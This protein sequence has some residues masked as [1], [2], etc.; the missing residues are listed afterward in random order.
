MQ[1]REKVALDQTNQPQFSGFN[2]D[3]HTTQSLTSWT[4]K[5]HSDVP[6]ASLS[7]NDELTHT[8]TMPSV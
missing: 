3:P 8:V 5:I 6:V 1:G 4:S 2:V 7:P